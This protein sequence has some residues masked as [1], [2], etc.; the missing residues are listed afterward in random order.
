M[1]TFDR[2]ERDIPASR[3]DSA[4]RNTARTPYWL[5]DPRRPGSL[6]SARGEL[7]TD[8]AIVG[9]GYTGLWTALLAKERDPN[10]RVILLEGKQVGWAASGRNGGFC[11]ASLTHGESNGQRHLPN[12]LETLQELGATN[13]REIG[14]TVARYNMDCD[15]EASGVLRIATEDY[16]VEWLKEDSAKKPAQVFMDREQVRK[17]INSPILHA[18]LW[19]KTDNVLVNP[20]RLAWE[21]RRVCIE[22]GV[23]IFEHSPVIDLKSTPGSVELVVGGVTSASAKEVKATVTAPRVALGTNIFPSL[24]HRMRPYTVPVWDYAL[25]SNPLTPEQ[26][27]ALGWKSRQGLAD[28]NNRFHYL[29]MTRDDN[30]HDRI[31]YGGYDAIYHYGQRLKPEY[32]NREETYRKLAAH[33]YATFPILGDIGFSHAWGGAIDSCSRFFSFFTRSLGD[34]VVGSAGY[35]GLGVGATRFGAN[36][37]LDL[38]DGL[39]TERTRL[40]LVKKKPIP[41]PPEPAA[42]LGVQV[43]T[44]EMARSDRRQGKRGLWLSTMDAIGMGFDS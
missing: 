37:I 15:Y 30:G 16:Q 17:E 3:I 12:E 33:F 24:L 23:E 25:M 28:L 32:Y 44:S 5:D 40:E 42:W 7:R 27:D 41:F 2:A 10:R 22:L 14:E 8:L 4:L 18:G 21:L 20:A 29:R 26:S 35:T 31:L 6:P 36:T 38:L 39:D 34:R 11:E 9:G 13:I 1:I 43:T 19:E